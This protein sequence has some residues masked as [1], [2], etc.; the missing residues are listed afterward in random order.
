MLIKWT[1]K[2]SGEQGFVRNIRIFRGYFE[3]T[4][5][6]KEAHVFNTTHQCDAALKL[7]RQFGETKQNRFELV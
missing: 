3:N 1:N 4:Y 6:I 7:L 5:D 2:I